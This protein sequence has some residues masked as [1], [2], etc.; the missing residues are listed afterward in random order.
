LV[1]TICGCLKR[2]KRKLISLGNMEFTAFAITTTGSTANAC[3][4]VR[5]MMCCS[6]ENQTFPFV[7]AGQMKTGRAGGMVKIRKF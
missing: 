4:S 6:H 5:L 7:S 2:G 1:S 3:S